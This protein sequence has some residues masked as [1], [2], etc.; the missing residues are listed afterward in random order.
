MEHVPPSALLSGGLF[1][2]TRE[3]S[4]KGRNELEGVEGQPA[5]LRL[6][7]PEEGKS[8]AS[9][10]LDSAKQPPGSSSKKKR[11]LLRAPTLD[12]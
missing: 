11:P 4:Q 2:N 5:L 9:V 6:P 1:R 8:K 10:A 3:K 12:L 7:L